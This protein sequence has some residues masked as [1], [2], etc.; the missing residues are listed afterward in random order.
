V[1]VPVLVLIRALWNDYTNKSLSI[2]QQ[3]LY[4]ARKC[5]RFDAYCL[6]DKPEVVS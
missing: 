4:A 6:E 2:F 3:I 5:G 1:Q